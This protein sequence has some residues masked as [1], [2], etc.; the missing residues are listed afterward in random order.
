MLIL[1]S[2][3]KKSTI[4]APEESGQF[5]ERPIGKALREIPCTEK[6]RLP[7]YK[8]KKLLRISTAITEAK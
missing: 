3:F 2:V 7:G 5:S 4:S 6:S 1:C 8:G